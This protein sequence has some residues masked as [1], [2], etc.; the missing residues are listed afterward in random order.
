MEERD[1]RR[2]A[3]TPRSVNTYGFMAGTT[4]ETGGV[5][6]GAL[7]CI[8]EIEDSGRVRTGAGGTKFGGLEKTRDEIMIRVCVSLFSTVSKSHPSCLVKMLLSLLM[9][10][11]L[12]LR[13]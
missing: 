10:F 6:E 13:I 7:K 3:G 5:G 11:F 4:L 12:R 2:L 8:K 1:S 9:L